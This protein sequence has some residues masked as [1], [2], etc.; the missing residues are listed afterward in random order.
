[1]VDDAEDGVG[2][3]GAVLLASEVDCPDL[4]FGGVVWFFL[5]YL[6]ACFGNRI[7]F[8]PQYICHI[9]FADGYP[10]FCCEDA[11]EKMGYPSATGI[12][13]KCFQAN[14]FSHDLVGFALAAINGG[15]GR[16]PATSAGF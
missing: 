15:Q 3:S 13:H 5:P 4:I 10:P 9:G 1:M 6:F 7:A 14:D 2:L 11:V 16:L 12:G 8:T